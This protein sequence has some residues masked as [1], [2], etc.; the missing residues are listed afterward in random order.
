M[1]SAAM[2]T[3]EDSDLASPVYWSRIGE[4]A[5]FVNHLSQECI[6]TAARK[7]WETESRTTFF[8]MRIAPSGRYGSGPES[9][10][11]ASLFRI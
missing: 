8:R 7:L 5:E 4:E 6:Q 9:H 1:F 11:T 3:K 10:S 2:R